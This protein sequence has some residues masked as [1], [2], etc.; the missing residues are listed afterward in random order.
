MT[1][2]HVRL[3]VPGREGSSRHGRGGAV[4]DRRPR[5]TGW[6]VA[7]LLVLGTLLVWILFLRGWA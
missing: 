1:A 7:A 6:L 5:T 3:S 4:A 2:S